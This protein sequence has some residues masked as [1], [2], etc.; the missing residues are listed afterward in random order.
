MRGID[1][2]TA[3]VGILTQLPGISKDIAYRIV[4]HRKAHGWFTAWEELAE[5]KNFPVNRLEEIKSR[6]MLSCHDEPGSCT[7]PRHLEKH[8][9]EAK[10]KPEGYTRALRS[11]RRQDRMK[12][13]IGP[14]H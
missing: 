2:N 14:R 1:L 6:A 12:E 9:E 3:G 7:P 13:S 4:N 5:I 8:V 10:K 11:T